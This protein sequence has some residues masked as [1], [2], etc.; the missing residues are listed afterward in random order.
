[1]KLAI[2]SLEKKRSYIVLSKYTRYWG[3]NTTLILFDIEI[4]KKLKGYAH[5]TDNC[6]Y[7]VLT[8]F[9]Y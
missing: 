2:N 6:Y 5:L 4:V 7:S 9:E 3:T 8:D 1:M